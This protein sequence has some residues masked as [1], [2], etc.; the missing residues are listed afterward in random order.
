MEFWGEI[1]FI[2]IEQQISLL[3]NI[4]S[5]KSIGLNQVLIFI[6]TNINNLYSWLNNNTFDDTEKEIHFFKVIKPR[7]VSYLLYYDKI[8]EIETNSHFSKHNKI[9]YLK[10]LQKE[11]DDHGEKYKS[12]YRYYYSKLTHKDEK[13]F[14]RNKKNVI[15]YHDSH[16]INYDFKVSSSHDH[17]VAT[18]ISN[19]KLI[20]YIE[21]LLENLNNSIKANESPTKYN[22]TGNKI[23]LV[24][25]IYALKE[26][27]V[28]NNGA[29]DIKEIAKLFE[30]MFNVELEENIYRWYFDIKKR[31]ISRTKFLNQLAENLNKKMDNEDE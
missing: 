1:Y 12:F 23:E 19:D 2:E 15:R 11:A 10:K 4:A 16:I 21:N 27:N 14:T 25:L 6:N 17:L 31:K 18:I 26:Q 13:Y 5:E 20:I 3:L 30:T 22:W 24:E 7:L 28:I 8:L 29:A 9:K